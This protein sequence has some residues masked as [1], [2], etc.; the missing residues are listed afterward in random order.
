MTNRT[1]VTGAAGV[2]GHRLVNSLVAR[3]DSVRAIDLRPRPRQMERSVDYVQAELTD[4]GAEAIRAFNP[5]TIFHLAGAS[6]RDLQERGD[7]RPQ[8]RDGVS[9]S[10]SVLAAAESC[11]NLRR[12]V[13]ASSYLV[14]NPELQLSGSPGSIP[15]V[16]VESEPASPRTV[17]G[18]AKLLH[19]LEL[20]L[21]SSQSQNFSSISAR[22]FRV[23]ALDSGDD[24]GECVRAALRG[25]ELQ[26]HGADRPF[27][28]VSADDVADGLI[29]LADSDATG[30]VNLGSGQARP[31]SD[32]IA[33]LR[34]HFP[35]LKVVDLGGTDDFEGCE[36]GVERLRELTGW[37]PR[38]SLEE[39][40]QRMVEAGTAN[41]EDAAVRDRSLPPERLNVLVSSAASKATVFDAMRRA[42]RS[43][44][45]EGEIWAGDAGPLIPAGV[46][47][48]AVWQM[49]RI[50]DLPV[51]DL[52]DFCQA[53]AIRMIIPTRDGELEYFA[54][55]RE[56]LFAAGI[57]VPIGSLESVL[58]CLD[59]VRTFEV[60]SSA[61]VATIPTAT[62]LG[63]LAELTAASE[64]YVVKPRLGA[65]SVDAAIGIG[66]DRA[67]ALLAS[68]TD[69]VVQPFV[70][71]QEYS[72]DQ[73]VTRG[74]DLIGTVV[75][76]RLLVKH[77]EAQITEV[78]VA[79]TISA[80]AQE[81]IAALG[82]TGHSVTQIIDSDVGPVVIECNSRIGGASNAAWT[83][84]LR[85]IDAMCLEALGATIDDRLCGQSLVRSTRL[86]RDVATWLG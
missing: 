4:G 27:D 58:N 38:T 64:Q 50:S 78:V 71:G 49:P 12:Y 46:V 34:G 21:V 36:A 83:A 1:I 70:A 63:D 61:G 26:V 31:L 67:E 54:A 23:Y 17:A 42:Q 7:W 39:G 44:H 18:V 22:I 9:A 6:E 8:G 10:A 72:V 62:R 79:P 76:T 81:A 25:E 37:T 19:E 11:V 33:T 85:S 40:V 60:L 59:K 47:A 3:G 82:V 57:F 84:G 55:H 73:Y 75:R 48:D 77:G 66:G 56:S 51:K 65:G 28:Y 15:R 20:D 32:V 5:T 24:V 80:V 43:L 53:H 35:D 45:L 14:Y 52:V 69:L 74:G 16:L 29:R 41:A 30:V 2:I 13:F 86:V 68:G